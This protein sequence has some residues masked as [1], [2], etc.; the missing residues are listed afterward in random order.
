MSG[1]TFTVRLLGA[2]ATLLLAAACGSNPV[3]YSA[4]ASAPRA[5][6]SGAP[7]TAPPAGAPASPPASSGVA[8]GGNGY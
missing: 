4:G 6:S 7:V 3:T 1:S 8:K 5:A 2:T